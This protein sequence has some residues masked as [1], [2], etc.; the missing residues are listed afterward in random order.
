LCFQLCKQRGLNVVWIDFHLA[1]RDLIEGRAMKTELTDSKAAGGICARGVAFGCTS[2]RAVQRRA[3]FHADRRAEDAAGQGTVRVEIAKT[4]RWVKGGAR[5]IIAEV[6]EA[7][8]RS[9][10]F[11]QRACLRV[12][13]E[14]G[15]ETFPRCAGPATNARGAGRIF[16]RELAEAF[17]QPRC[18]ELVNGEDSV[19][20]L[21]AT[22][23]AYEE[24]AA[25]T[26]RVGERGIEDL[27]KL[28][29]A[30]GACISTWQVG[31]QELRRFR[32]RLTM[33]LFQNGKRLPVGTPTPLPPLFF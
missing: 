8:L 27:H 22:G 14:I 33:E 9:P 30:L 29:V 13:R 1:G 2:I 11:R 10:A 15:R 25:A 32:R 5:L 6:F 21:R 7:V 4:G 18:V 31:F 16:C 26:S 19:A 17:A 24:I 20:T 12:T 3:R 23:T 28:V